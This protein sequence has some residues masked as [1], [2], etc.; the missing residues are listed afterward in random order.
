MLLAINLRSV[1]AGLPPLIADVRAD[2]GLSG[3]AAGVL[4]TLPVLCMGAFAPVAPRLAARVP[5][6]RALVGCALLTAA[7]TGIR[8][9]G[10]TA[11]CSPRGWRSAWRSRSRRRCCRS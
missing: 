6:E 10:T 4:T 11:R 8:A 2:L 1:L 3:A 5:I 7:G 9:L